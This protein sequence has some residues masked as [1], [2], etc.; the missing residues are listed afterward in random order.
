MSNKLSHFWQELKRRKVMPFLIGY[1]AAC[2]AIISFLLD[3]SEIFSVPDATIRLLYLLSAIGIPVV[4]FFPWHFNR[5]KSATISDQSGDTDT[6]ANL[7]ISQIHPN[8]I[9]VL[10]FENISPILI[11]SISVMD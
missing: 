3:S 4:I 1:V 6:A 11:R 5:K 8:S 9:I 10:P 2:F 7:D